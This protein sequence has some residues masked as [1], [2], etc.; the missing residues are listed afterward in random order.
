MILSSTARGRNA[1]K[2]R[3]AV[4]LEVVWVNGSSGGFVVWVVLKRP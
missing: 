4:E 2:M 3:L 1:R